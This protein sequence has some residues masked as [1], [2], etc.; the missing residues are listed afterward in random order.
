MVSVW[1][2][3]DENYPHYDMPYGGGGPMPTGPPM[4]GSWVGP[5]PGDMHHPQQHYGNPMAPRG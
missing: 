3:R 4:H 1:S 5:G 2:F